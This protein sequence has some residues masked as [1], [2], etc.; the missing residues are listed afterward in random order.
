MLYSSGA[1]A[2]GWVKRPNQAF[3]SQTPLQRMRAGDITDLAAPCISRRGQGAVELSYGATFCRLSSSLTGDI[4]ALST[5]QLFERLTPD[6]AVWEVLIALQQLTSPRLRD[7][8]G[9][10]A[11]VPPDER[12]TGPGASYVMASFTHLNLKGRRFS[13]G[14]F[15]VNYAAAL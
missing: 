12:V 2:D 14:S 9:G 7:E 11:L 8:I 5:D 13:D 15:G 1:L 3:G 4:H 6:P 10:I